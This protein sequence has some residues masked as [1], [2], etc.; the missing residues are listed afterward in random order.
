[1]ESFNINL[2]NGVEYPVIISSKIFENIEDHLSRIN[3]SGELYFIVDEYIYKKYFNFFK[4]KYSGYSAYYKVVLG[5]KNNKT[6]FSAMQIF[7]DLDGKNISRDITIV[8]VGG[9]VIGDLAGF[10]ASCWYRG[11]KLVHFPTTLLAAVDSC[12]GGKT[13]INFRQTI[14]AVGTYHHPISIFVDTSLLHE[15]PPREVSSGFGE[16]IKYAAIG[17]AKIKNSIDIA[18]SIANLN[19]ETLV[20]ESLREKER[21]VR[22]DIG[23][24]ANRLFLNFGHTI[25]HSIEF[26]TV[27]NGEETLRHGEGV[28]LGMV[29]IFRICVSLSLL[30]EADLLWLKGVLKKCGLPSAFEASKVGMSTQDLQEQIS[31]LCFK[32]KKRTSKFLRLVL[33]DG[34]GRPII[35]K[36]DDQELILHGV[37]EVI[38]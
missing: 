17:N 28:A 35:Y 14:N 8:A 13:A 11:V 29:A 38:I 36:T 23:E 32:D 22:G 19:L 15:L 3:I 2:G 33:L 25:G 16:I 1:M 7:A 10:V 37:K 27:Y 31:L 21:F 20:A 12:V 6:L 9:G 18:D 24:S 26:S 34:I 5:K 30:K 4:N